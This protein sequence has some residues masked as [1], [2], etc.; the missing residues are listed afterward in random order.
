VKGRWGFWKTFIIGKQGNPMMKRL[1]VIQTPWFG[2][3]LHF[4]YREDLDPV[5]H[6]HPWNFYRIVLRGGYVEL[7]FEDPATGRGE[8]TSPGRRRWSYV[9]ITHAHRITN[10]A[11]KTVSLVVVGPK[12]RTWGFWSPEVLGPD[13]VIAGGKRQWIDYRDALGLRPT[14]GVQ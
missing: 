5:P 8:L 9:P 2:V 4:I 3:Y 1:R 6:D 14:E 11:P 10:V 12:V 7:Y 13:L